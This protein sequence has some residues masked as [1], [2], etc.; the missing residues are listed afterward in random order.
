[1]SDRRS[2]GDG[3][4]GIGHVGGAELGHAGRKTDGRARGTRGVRQTDV[5]SGENS[6]AASGHGAA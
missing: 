5:R 4:D 1:M 3:G 2:R 6:G